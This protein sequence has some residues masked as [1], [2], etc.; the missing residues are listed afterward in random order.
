MDSI[1]RILHVE[2]SKNDAELILTSLTAEGFLCNVT[3]VE[4]K[5]DFIQKVEQHPF[6]LILCDYNL[7]S[8]D[9]KSVLDIAL[10]LCPQ[11]PFIFVS[12][13]I[14][15][16]RAIET[17]KRGATDYVLKNDLR[18]LGPVVKRALRE[19][20][21]RLHRTLA[22]QALE[23]SHNQLKYLFDNLDEVFFS[24]DVAQNTLLQGSPSHKTVFGYPLENFYN[25]PGL[26]YEL[27]LPEDRAIVDANSRELSFGKTVQYQYRIRR[28]D[29][30]LRWLEAKIKPS[31]DTNG[32]L[33]RLDGLVGDITD[34]KQAEE[35]L[36]LQTTYFQQ[37]FENSPE[38]IVIL[39]EQ[40][41]VVNVNKSFETMFGYSLDELQG[42]PLNE[43]IVPPDKLD[44]AL[45]LTLE[46]MSGHVVQKDSMRKRKDG[47]MLDVIIIGFPIM[48]QERR[49]GVY[50]IYVDITERKKLTSQFYKNQ[51][52]ESIGILAG[53]IA[54]DFNNI[55]GIIMGH[56]SLL[57]LTKADPKKLLQSIDT[58][59]R[60][61]E[62]GASVVK[63]LLT[64]AR[65]SEIS[66]ESVS[67]NS[68]VLEIVK[69]LQETFPKT[70]EITTAL[71]QSI[72]QI[73]ADANQIHQVLLNL[74]VN[75]RDAMQRGGTLELSTS[76]VSGESLKQRGY[77]IS[78]PEYVQLQVMDTGMGMD[79]ETRARIFEPF[80]TT[81]E[82]G[83]GT[84]LGLAVVFGIIESHY[85]LIDVQSEVGRGTTFSFYFPVRPVPSGTLKPELNKPADVP[86]GTETLL[87]VEDEQM[88]RELLSGLL[89]EKGYTVLTAADGKEAITL[90]DKHKTEISL[91]LCDLDLPKLD[92]H[93]VL[94][95]IKKINPDV[96]FILAS[97]Y[98]DPVQKIEITKS[99][100]SAI[101]QKPY[102]PG[103]M[104]KK[105]RAT[106]DKN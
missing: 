51:R 42:H 30:K 13:T 53:G 50:G 97:G 76:V 14:G 7:P 44:E 43:F 96:K 46:S 71:D 89:V 56:A 18:R 104:M 41:S 61:A 90:Y 45:K 99:G 95:E 11:T 17:L 12:G 5:D 84:G 94:K 55:L 58:I 38:G 59:V 68:S 25:N 54:H 4:N 100:L 26:Y 6:D 69:L 63:Q 78:A 33:S 62:R 85:G 29:G 32:I 66:I 27:I 106:L 28:A 52:L 75:A 92:G 10:K 9:G 47:T 16:A 73:V 82:T 102:I 23:A 65:K 87:L 105:I 64:F 39:D 40:D 36:L 35:D 21:E 74:C 67:L 1:L 77:S 31:L 24:I 72:P 88:L 57:K 91:V 20:E 19:T 70:I 49:V 2:D 22:E 3:L 60:A 80:F 93:E 79:E 48:I 86:G 15:E 83:K 103:E 8:I 101:L 81:K 98:I 34:R 37:L